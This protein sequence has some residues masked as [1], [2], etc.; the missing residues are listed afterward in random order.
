MFVHQSLCTLITNALLSS[1]AL[2]EYEALRSNNCTIHGQSIVTGEGVGPGAQRHYKTCSSVALRRELLQTAFSW[3]HG[4][5]FDRVAESQRAD[6]AELFATTPQI[7]WATSN[8][9]EQFVA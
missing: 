3:L 6:V 7:T 8:W 4:H 2:V 9:H 1:L 5:R